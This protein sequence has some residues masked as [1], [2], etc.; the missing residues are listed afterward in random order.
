M[1]I[2]FKSN[3]HRRTF[4]EF[5]LE[6][7][8]NPYISRYE[9]IAAVYLL[10]A[11]KFLWKRTRKSL[12]GYSVDFEHPDLNGIS[13]EGYALYKAAKSIYMGNSEI[14]LNE[15]GDGDLIDHATLLTI[16]SGIMLLRNGIGMLNWE[17]TA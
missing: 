10:S 7:V 1:K 5:I 9:F 6:N 17:V 15:L 2:K 12:T 4:I 13:T 11:D 8:R 16:F 3:F 14:S